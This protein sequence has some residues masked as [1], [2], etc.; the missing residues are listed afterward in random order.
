VTTKER[1]HKL[2]DELSKQEADATLDFLVSRG[3]GRRSRDVGRR[4]PPGAWGE[5]EMLPLPKGWGWGWG[6]PPSGRSATNWVAGLDE[7]RRGR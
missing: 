4:N 5:P 2:V 3:E 6:R 7:V 1:L